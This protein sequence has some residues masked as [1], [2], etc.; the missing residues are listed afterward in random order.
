MTEYQKYLEGTLGYYVADLPNKNKIA[1]FLSKGADINSYFID[2]T[3]VRDYF[4]RGST[5]LYALVDHFNSFKGKNKDKALELIQ[6][7]LSKGANPNIPH[8][9][10]HEKKRTPKKPA[11]MNARD[12]ISIVPLTLAVENR[13]N[14]IIKLLVEHG[15]TVNQYHLE[16]WYQY[17]RD[18]R[19]PNE[20]E[21]LREIARVLNPAYEDWDEIHTLDYVIENRMYPGIK[22]LLKKGKKVLP[23][24]IEKWMSYLRNETNPN[25]LQKLRE[26]MVLLKP[27]YKPFNEFPGRLVPYN[28]INIYS[29]DDIQDGNIM[30][31]L[32]KEYYGQP[33]V[34]GSHSHFYK[35]DGWNMAK[36][37]HNEYQEE[38]M[39]EWGMEPTPIKSPMTRKPVETV[40]LYRAEKEPHPVEQNFR[41]IQTNVFQ[42]GKKSMTR[43]LKQNLRRK[44]AKW[45]R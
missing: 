24:H 16:T 8:V 10:I 33:G 15:A 26:I 12:V 6:F 19:S 36:K 38:L 40:N 17:L 20:L 41:A 42:G 5:L 35:K 34:V 28:A 11:Y 31:N 44:T 37:K 9:Y 32:N 30:V 1:S 23:Q 7:V 13:Y 29:Q 3:Y 25:E 21:K 18:A 43:K 4:T 14:P 39:Y 27:D 22:A 45:I 2:K